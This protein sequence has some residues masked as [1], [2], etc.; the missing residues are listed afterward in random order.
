MLKFHFLLF[1]LSLSSGHMQ[2]KVA[3]K[4]KLN[5]VMHSFDKYDPKSVDAS[6]YFLTIMHYQT[7]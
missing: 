3:A 7:H 1:P 2:N 6:I 5:P 4:T